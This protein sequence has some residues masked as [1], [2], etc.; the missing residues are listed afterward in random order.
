MSFERSIIIPFELYKKCK[1]PTTD[2]TS[3]DILTNKTL[4]SDTKLK[5]YDQAVISEK[6]STSSS[7]PP[8][9]VNAVTKGQHILHNIPDKDKPVV[10][11]ILD[12]IH[13]NDKILDYND[14]LEVIIDGQ[15][16]SGSHLVNIL[17]YLTNNI[18]VTSEKDVPEGA[19]EVYTRLIELGM[20]A[21]WI[22][23]VQR[24]KRQRTSSRIADA[25]R[26]KFQDTKWDSIT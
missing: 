17:L 2:A 25:K 11:S 20:P 21:V 13:D 4:P 7:S 19:H 12:I 16:I 5:L 8:P 24:P 1:L 14:N 6:H 26:R 3:L 10:R 18:P 22:K 15:R 23:K 9:L